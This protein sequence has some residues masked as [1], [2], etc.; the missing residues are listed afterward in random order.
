MIIHA[1]IRT[2][3]KKFSIE[4]GKPWVISVKSPP[5]RGMANA[6]IIMELSKFYKDVRILKGLKSKK[7][8]IFLGN[9]KT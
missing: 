4:K 6:E 5:E 3:Q 1:R 2:N 9:R 8:L 7:K